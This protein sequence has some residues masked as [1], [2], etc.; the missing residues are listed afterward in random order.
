MQ[1]LFADLKDALHKEIKELRGDLKDFGQDTERDIQSMMPQTA[2]LHQA[3]F[4]MHV[5]KLD[6]KNINIPANIYTWKM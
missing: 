6:A 4:E 2:D 3:H 1:Q 5:N